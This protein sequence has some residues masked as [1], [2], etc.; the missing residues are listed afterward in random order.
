MWYKQR[1]VQ[2]QNETGAPRIDSWKSRT[3]QGS[4]YLLVVVSLYYSWYIPLIFYSITFCQLLRIILQLLIRW[5]FLA[6]FW[7]VYCQSSRT[8]R[9]SSPRNSGACVVRGAVLGGCVTGGGLRM[10]ENRLETRMISMICHKSSQTLAIQDPRTKDSSAFVE[11]QPFLDIP[12]LIHI[13]LRPVL[14]PSNK[15]KV[16][17]S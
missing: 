16:N 3:T 12:I 2:K 7:I 4:T 5:H 6:D 8:P 15:K 17:D 10:A 14:K 11:Y 13:H 1:G 9:T